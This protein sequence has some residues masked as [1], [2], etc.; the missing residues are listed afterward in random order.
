[1]KRSRGFT[2][3]E[4]LVV[5]AVIGILTTISVV[6]YNRYQANSRDTQRA[7]KVTAIAE[8]LEKYYDQHGEYP[9]CSQLTQAAT[10]ITGS[11]GIIQG[12]DRD[13]LVAPEASAGTTNSLS[14]SGLSYGSSD[15]FAYVGDGSSTCTTGTSCLKFTLQYIDET[16]G[17]VATITSRRSTDFNTSGTITDL[18]ASTDATNGFSIVNLTW[19]AVSN[20][21]SYT[22]QYSTDNF[23]SSI[24]TAPTAPTTNSL[25]I[26]GLT[27]GTTYQFRV[28]GVTGGGVINGWSNTA[29]ATTWS[30]PPPT[31]IA[32]TISSNSLGFSW[33]SVTR[34]SSYTY[35]MATD[36]GFNSLVGGTPLTTSS[37]SA[38]VSGLTVGQQ[39]YIRVDA[40]ALSGTVDSGPS[41]TLSLTTTVPVPTGLTATT[42]SNTQITANWSSVS[43]ATSYTLTYSTSS[44]FTSPTSITGI[45]GTSQAVTGLTQG[46]TYY[47]EVFAL[48][49]ATPSAASSSANATTTV[50]TPGAPG[51]TAYRPNAIRAQGAANWIVSPP[52][53]GNWYYAYADIGASSCPSGT[54]AVFTV[55]FTYNSPLAWSYTG[56]T[57]TTPW[58]AQQPT[59]AYHI[60]FGAEQYCQ[61]SN[62][63]SGYGGWSYSCA[64]GSGSTETCTF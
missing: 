51:I 39:Y 59:A 4:L 17:Q 34:A 54:S 22:V 27:L 24:I 10:T 41:N 40:T 9:G 31:V 48:V 5:I 3:V 64:S 49:G 53:P 6:G 35:R 43:V 47:F 60:K 61:G 36:S 45:S 1:M 63:S 11:G 62:A 32:G 26:S 29:T 2:I 12:V 14:C 42:N 28:E 56:A 18:N 25:S 52:S 38:T 19:T 13:A 15:Y 8:A 57:S 58:Y 44:S 55:G 20:A 7:A 46:K 23:N 50:A 21:A 16:D 30:L 33:N 37:T